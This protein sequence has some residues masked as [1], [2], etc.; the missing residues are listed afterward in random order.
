MEEILQSLTAML[1][2]EGVQPET[3]RELALSPM[4]AVAK[5]EGAQCGVAFRFGR[6]HSIY[7]APRETEEVLLPLREMIGQP[8]DLL[9]K[10]LAGRSDIY[11]RAFSLAALNAL[12]APLNQADRLEKR[13]W[14]QLPPAALP[15]LKPEDRV[16]CIGYGYLIDQVLAVCPQVHVSDMRP[17]AVL[18]TCFLGR[19]G[20]V[21]HGPERVIFHDA[22]ENEAL[23]EEADIVLMTGCT[24]VN[25]T[26]RSLL[27]S[28]VR[29]RVRGI[30]G[31]SAGLPPELLRDMGFNYMT[32]SAV[33]RPDVLFQGLHQPMGDPFGGEALHR[34]SLLL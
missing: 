17:K 5:G 9:V 10:R 26:W 8:L 6:D 18:E 30:F 15:F 27:Q 2:A 24:L 21:G 34:F 19:E 31:P 4:W 1:Q 7:G 14:K 23:L 32:A 22:S 12:S 3:L 11:S 28:S 29:A 13:G 16:V 33:Q 20:T 25:G